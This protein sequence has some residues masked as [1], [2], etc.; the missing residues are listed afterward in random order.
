MSTRQVHIPKPY[1]HILDHRT[2]TTL[3]FPSSASSLCGGCR[4][5][6]K[7]QGET[8]AWEK[9]R[10]A[11][12]TPS[13]NL[14]QGHAKY[15][16][17]R[18]RPKQKMPAPGGPGKAKAGAKTPAGKA[19]PGP[20][21]AAAAIGQKGSKKKDN[22][23]ATAAAIPAAVPIAQQYEGLSMAAL[24]DAVAQLEQ[25]TAD[26]RMAH[27]DAKAERDSR[28]QEHAATTQPELN[29]ATQALAGMRKQVEDL[30][31][32]HR[33][34]LRV[35]QDKL[36]AL[37]YYHTQNLKSVASER[38]QLLSK[39]ASAHT[40]NMCML[41]TKHLLMSSSSSS[42]GGQHERNEDE[43]AVLRGRLAEECTHLQHTLE[44]NLLDLQ[45]ACTDRIAQLQEDLELRRKTE[46]Q[47]LEERADRH[48]Q[49]VVQQHEAVMRDLQQYYQ[50]VVEEQSQRLQAREDER[51]AAETKAKVDCMRSEKLGEAIAQLRQPL[52]VAV[53]R[54]T[55]L[56]K[57]LKT[58]PRDQASLQ[59][60]RGRL[61]FLDARTR[62][63]EQAQ[64]VRRAAV[65]ALM[66]EE[67]REVGVAV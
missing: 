11:Q 17:P 38:A 9:R 66:E 47:G 51:A 61:R 4:R 6:Q 50:D 43:G 15:Q 34:E 33:L 25:S 64:I 67:E 57:A 36:I 28:H 1:L 20:K 55:E 2:G 24:Q 16:G 13:G 32:D 45:S 42:A 48:R 7:E 44:A 14:K 63:L 8:G 21:K 12:G 30:S 58:R 54:E 31:T 39:E 41:Q 59:H 62:E 18:L 46:M 5:P 27:A 29:K 56:K 26:A 49:E 65:E 52:A 22:E 40:T 10:H 19:K 53:S 60:A 35:Y 3:L 23:T 37:N